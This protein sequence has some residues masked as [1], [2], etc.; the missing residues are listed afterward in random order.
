MV[1]QII[2]RVGHAGVTHTASFGIYLSRYYLGILTPIMMDGSYSCF[3]CVFTVIW[4]V[5]CVC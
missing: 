4:S 3:V 2:V 1:I 5:K